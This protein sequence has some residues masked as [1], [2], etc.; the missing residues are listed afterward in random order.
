MMTYQSFRVVPLL[1]P[2]AV[3]STLL[4]RRRQG[5]RWSAIG[6]G[7]L[8]AGTSLVVF[9]PVLKFALVGEHRDIFWSRVLTRAT[10][11]ERPIVGSPL[12]IFARNLGNMAAAFHWRG[13]S[14]WTL[15]Y[16]YDP[17]LD[18]VSG[19][20]LLAGLVLALRQAL[21][22][23][24]RW[25]FLLVLPFILTLP[26]TLVL[27]YPEENPSVNRAS[28]AIPVVFVLVGAPV[29]FLGARFARERTLLRVAGFA[30][31]LG[32]AV[33]SARENADAYFGRLGTSYDAL[34]D[35]AMEVA[36]VMARYREAGI[37]L[38]QQYLLSSRYWVDARNV[39]FELGDPPWAD[40]HNVAP[41]EAPEELPA[42]PLAFVYRSSD[43]QRLE[44]LQRL[45]PRGED[46]LFPQSFPDR[47]F[48]VYV[49][50]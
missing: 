17:L 12:R 28:A 33:V 35:H 7:L 20:L 24:W 46:R 38:S 21:S 45:Y 25:A 41:D 6:D 16:R 13:S 19:A 36:A 37:P 18:A 15:L 22:G 48:S 5:R 26:S 4:D 29:A 3:A 39:A 42:R 40:T 32:A 9:L 8:A 49:V 50:R 10:S 11:V 30:A 44:T 31:L 34:V 2:L 23:S 47:N 43:H 1:V 14:T 27:S